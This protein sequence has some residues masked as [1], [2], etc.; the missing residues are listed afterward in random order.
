MLSLDELCDRATHRLLA[1]F[2]CDV[3]IAVRPGDAGRIAA[4]FRAASAEGVRAAVW[5]MLDDAQGRWLSVD[6]APAFA[7]FAEQALA[8][9]GAAEIVFDLEPLHSRV[10]DVL[11]GD[12]RAIAEMLRPAFSRSA[13]ASGQGAFGGLFDRAARM[14]VRVTAAVAPLLLLDAHE[15][16]PFGRILGAPPPGGA[17]VNV[18]LYSTLFSGYSRG[19]LRRA[20]ARAL[21]A[22]GAS[23]AVRRW[24]ERAHVSLGAVGVGALG[25]EAVYPDPSLLAD[26]VAL[27]AAAGAE[28]LW[29]LDLGGVVFRGAPER[30]LT[31]FTAP[32]VHDER[33]R[34]PPR[35]RA[36]ALSL[37][38]LSRVIEWIARPPGRGD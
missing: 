6:N 35:A 7:P 3:A 1:R 22:A 18:M 26:D 21:L 2:G 10:R 32:P 5:P 17:S 38:G 34:L 11:D 29:L 19:L 31:A 28:S 15:P 12:R 37:A 24:G 4:P 27:A 16:G 25:D 23:L 30:W 9:S 33:P 14:G 20:D 8:E 36:A 13:V